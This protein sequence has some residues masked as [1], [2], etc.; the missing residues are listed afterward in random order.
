MTFNSFRVLRHMTRLLHASGDTALAK[1]TLKLYVQVV[2]KAWQTSGPGDLEHTDT[3][4]NWV[5]TLVAGVR[6]LCSSV[7]ASPGAPEGLQ[8]A[9]DA[10]KLVEKL[11][12]R[13][14]TTNKVLAA[15]VDLAEGVWCSVFASKGIVPLNH[16]DGNF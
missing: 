4:Q 13:L 11:R 2:G 15:S 10:G 7:A 12:T 14:D 5:E 8:D 1:R 9:R 16:V 6:M 3:D